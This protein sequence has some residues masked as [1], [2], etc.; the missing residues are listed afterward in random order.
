MRRVPLLAV[1]SMIL[2]LGVARAAQATDVP[3][4]GLKL[5]VVDKTATANIAKAVFV[6]KDPAIT[7]GPGVDP[8]Q[9]AA[10]LDVA[11]DTVSG[12]FDMPQGTK[13]LVNSASVGKYVNKAAPTGGAAKVSVLKPGSLVKVVGKSLGDTPLDISVA[14]TGVV[15]VA[16]TI[17]NGAETTRLCT[18]FNACVHKVIGGGTGYKLICKGNSTGDA[19]CTAAVPPTSTSTSTSST[20][21]VTST[22]T[23]TTSTTSTTISACFVDQGLTVLDTCTNLEWE[24]KDGAD[25]TP[26]EGAADVGNLHDVDNRYGWSG[27]CSI[28]T[29][30][31]CQPNAAA[32]AA[33]K[34]Q[35]DPGNWGYGCEQC[36]GGEG[37]CT[38]YSGTMITTVWDWVS[39]VN[40]A[41]FG[42]HSD[43]RLPSEDGQNTSPSTDPRELETILTTPLPL[44]PGCGWPAT[45]IAPIFG[46]TAPSILYWSSS[47]AWASGYPQLAYA[48]PFG[49]GYISASPKRFYDLVVRAVRD[50]S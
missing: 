18:Q 47:T 36:L 13:W 33:C 7:K 20:T 16:D 4:T 23:S 12:A 26:G 9:I 14:P 22:S 48:V 27:A 40:A 34:A 3:I 43:W 21:S 42:G 38:M 46:P 5:I 19:A 10:T 32:E 25:A 39:Q 24:K 1:F 15:Y 31:D 11:Y 35:T 49:S 37:A 17:I 41:N 6:A 29:V 28:N 30:K 50:G 2:L 44:I 45:C 8:S